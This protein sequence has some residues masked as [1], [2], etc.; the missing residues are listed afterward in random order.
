MKKGKGTVK[1][2]GK[3][4]KKWS[5]KMWS[6]AKWKYRMKTSR[7]QSG[8]FS[9]E[10]SSYFGNAQNSSPSAELSQD[11]FQGSFLFATKPAAKEKKEPPK[12]FGGFFGGTSR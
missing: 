12:A 4:S 8:T 6:E 5:G 1:K 9:G 2:S 10:Y 3:M 11:R 7:E